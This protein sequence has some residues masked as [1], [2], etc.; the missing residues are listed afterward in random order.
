M[1]D[2]GTLEVVDNAVDQTTGTVRMKGGFPN[3]D[4]QL[5][6]GQFINLR[7]YVDVLRG[8]VTVPT[9][10]VQ[11]GP[12]GAFVYVVKNDKAV[13]TKVTTGR[14]TEAETVVAA[15][16][17]P[18]ADVV[19]TGFSRLTDGAAVAVGAAEAAASPDAPSRPA[20]QGRKAR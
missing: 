1:L 2:A 12:D 14:Q 15:G 5:W 18:P 9:A 11:R 4:G 16:L 3:A 13:M 20:G 8:A 7:L 19:T 6:P 17:S 10:A